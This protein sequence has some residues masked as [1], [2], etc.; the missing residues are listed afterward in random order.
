MKRISNSI[1][2]KVRAELA[3]LAAMPDDQIDTHDIPGA[4]DWSGA[5]RGRFYRPIKKQLTLRLDGDVVEWF[6]HYVHRGQGYQTQINSALRH[7]VRVVDGGVTLRLS[8]WRGNQAALSNFMRH[9]GLSA[10]KATKFAGA[11]VNGEVVTVEFPKVRDPLA[12]AEQ[13][14]AIGIEEV[15][16]VLRAGHREPV[17]EN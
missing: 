10:A 4:L 12:V 2:K 16:I 9:G 5:Q 8:G 1:S 14:S 11:I 6:K 15:S 13:L 17:I 3:A 7:Y